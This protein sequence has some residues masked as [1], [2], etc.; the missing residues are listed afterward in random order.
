MIK[1]THILYLLSVCFSLLSLHSHANNFRHYTISEGLSVNAVYSIMQDSKGRMWFG[2]IDGLHSFDGNRIRVWR[3]AQIATLGP[4]IYTVFEHDRHLYVGSDEGLSLFDLRMESFSEFDVR[5]EAGEGIRTPVRHVMKDSKGNL[6]ISTLGQGVFRYNP[7]Q[8]KLF[9]YV[10]PGKSI[11]DFVYSVTEDSSGTIWLATQDAGIGRYIVSK[12]V[13]Q[14]IVSNLHKSIRVIFED[15]QHNLWAGSSTEGLFRVDKSAKQLVPAVKPF[16]DNRPLQVRKIVE[17]SIG[18]LMFASDE[19]LT[20]YNTGTGEVT[21]LKVDSKYPDGLNDNYLHDLFIDREGSLWIGTYFGGVNYVSATGNNY[22]HYNRKN[23]QLDARIVSVFAKADSDNLWIGTDDAGVFYWNRRDNTFKSYYSATGKSA[24][25]YHN[26]HALMQ[27]GDKL[28]IGMYMGGLD[29][30]NLK[31][32]T[33]K[34]YKAMPSP[35]SLYSS[36]IYALYKDRRNQIWVGT[37]QGLNRY[38]AENDRFIRVY[39]VKS[40]DVSC[41]LEDSEG[42]LWVCSLNNGIFRFNYQEQEWKHFRHSSEEGHGLITDQI[43]TAC[44]DEKGGLWFGTY[45]NGLMKYDYKSGTFARVD[46]PSYIRVVHKIIADK[47]HLWFT[48]NNGLYCYDPEK[49][50]TKSYNKY[51]GLQENLFLP[52]SGIQLPD[53]TIMVGGI[54]GFNEFHPDK[55]RHNSQVPAVILTDFQLFNQ[56]VKIGSEHSPLSMSVTYSDHLTLRHE[57]SMFSFTAVTLSYTNPSKNLYR[58]KLD[59]FEKEWTETDAPPRVTYTNLPAGN[60]VFRVSASNADGV[61]N[62][63]AVALPIKILPPWWRSTP[64]IFAYVLIVIGSL[65]YVFYRINRK[66]R[67]RI[68]VLTMEKDKEIYQSKIEFFTHIMH[69]IRTPLTLIL[70]PLENVM[71]MN[72]TIK[73][74][75]PKLQT[76]E[77]NGKRL[78]TL[79]NQLMDFRKVESGR[80]NLTLTVADIKTLLAN[81]YQRFQLSAEMKQIE[82]ITSMPEDACYVKVDPE[83]FTKIVS[84]LLSNALKF[85]RTHIWIDLMVNAGGKVELRVK[86]DGQGIPA[87]D[88][89]KIFMPFYQVAENRK[90]DS[91]GTGIGLSLVKKLVDMMNG[92][93]ALES[94]PGKGTAFIVRFNAETPPEETPE[95][96]RPE[97]TL[98]SAAEAVGNTG[99]YHI[100]VVDDNR[101]LRD[102]LQSLLSDYRVTCASDGQEAWDLLPKIMPDLIISDVMMPVMSG[103]QLCRKVKETLSVSHIPVILLTAKATTDDYVEGF[104]SG[105]D[106]YIEKPFSADVLKAQIGSLFK[107]RERSRREF[108]SEPMASSAGMSCSKLDAAFMEKVA[109]IVEERMADPDFT[110]DILAQEAGIS[111]S[112]LFNKLKAIAGMTPNDYVRLIRLKKA[113]VLLAEEGLSSSEACFQVGFS[114]PSYFAKCFQTQFGVS[115]TG[116]RKKYAAQ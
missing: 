96:E 90:A 62:K 65:V 10:A 45:G 33:F 104:D 50:E 20:E 21:S 39:E 40:A 16:G 22:K 57:H 86:D 28:Y 53:G 9:Q 47:G 80:M 83:A 93:L 78:L 29:I 52:N 59:G 7:Q 37:T 24:P 105:A 109:K 1:K 88:R 55:I 11:S 25:S 56:P 41:I 82:L 113:A 68:A 58:Y 2:T 72:G 64:M 4:Y 95:A 116:F 101:D 3:D 36:E 15:S 77:R 32:G 54:N 70:A 99:Q 67:K 5:T 89:E 49:E 26:I 18:V 110:I 79:V 44:I 35:Y 106:I 102:Y 114:S 48:T 19:G 76:I 94:E 30:L 31:T 12:D 13:F 100:L 81:V 43:V 63:D 14:P 34:N 107:N 103:I 6:W 112:G 115:P 69:E 98:P 85:T 17:K 97:T 87:K 23:S 74:A 66:H 51:D 46:L 61:W 108:K 27:D 84:N 42:Y 75:L 92:E 8:G 71:Q 60:Y 111:R 91:V 73:D 38:D